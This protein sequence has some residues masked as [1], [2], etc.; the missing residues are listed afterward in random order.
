MKIITQFLNAYFPKGDYQVDDFTSISK[1]WLIRQTVIIGILLLITIIVTFVEQEGLYLALGFA[2][3]F[4]LVRAYLFY[5]KSK[6]GVNAEV[7]HIK[8]GHFG[9]VHELVQLHKIQGA[10]LQQS[11][12]QRRKKLASIILFT[13][14]GNI[15]MPYIPIEIARNYRD[16]IIR[17]VETDGRSWM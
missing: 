12:Y 8:S 6:I 4:L 9:D 13:A 3:A 2:F 7:I 15:K 16:Y 17:V 1:W 11:P 5:K 10:K 14:A